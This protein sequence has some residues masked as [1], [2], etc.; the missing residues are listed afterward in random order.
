MDW[1]YRLKLE[2]LANGLKITD[3]AR[4]QLRFI[5]PGR[6]ITLAEYATTSG[7]CLELE[8]GIWVNAPLEKYNPNFVFNPTAVLDFN[9]E[10]ASFFVACDDVEVIAKP[11]PVPDYHSESASSGEPFSRL[12]VTHTDRVRISPIEGCAYRCTFC[13]LPTA[14]PQYR[15]KS[16]SDLVESVERAICDLTLPARHILISGGT[17]APSDFDYLQEVYETITSSFPKLEVEVMMAPAPG[18]LKVQWLSDIGVHAV[19]AN[20]ELFGEDA[21]RRHAPNKNKL[22]REVFGRFFELAAATFGAGRVRSLLLVGLEPLEDTLAGVRFLAER[23]CQPI[24]SPFRPAPGTREEKTSPPS[25]QFLAEA[26]SR[27]REIVDQYG[28]GLGPECLPC[29]HN[30]LSFPGDP[31]ARR[32]TSLGH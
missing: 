32:T 7:I 25:I 20:L 15:R 18:L 21:V 14:F 2:L 4:S 17:P 11:I 28:V 31:V 6:P 5:H 16:I 3:R 29:Q 9:D 1:S 24:L 23:G 13:D 12:A 30:T 8:G 22:G 26:H 10:F 19:L 27:A